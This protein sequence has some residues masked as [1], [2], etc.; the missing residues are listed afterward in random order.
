MTAYQALIDRGGGVMA[1][2]GHLVLH[3][4]DSP[5]LNKSHIVHVPLA[6]ATAELLEQ[7]VRDVVRLELKGIR[8]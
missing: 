8:R 4:S 5:P 2:G 3:V 1:I 6:G 7:T